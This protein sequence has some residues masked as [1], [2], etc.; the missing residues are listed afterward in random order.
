VPGVIPP[1]DPEVLRYIT[2]LPPAVIGPPYIYFA[3][4]LAFVFVIV[5]FL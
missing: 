5:V 4:A 3:I 2:F 1:N